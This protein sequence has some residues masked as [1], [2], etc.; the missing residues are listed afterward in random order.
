MGMMQGTLG[1][2]RSIRYSVSDSSGTECP[3]TWIDTTPNT[4]PSVPLNVKTPHTVEETPYDVLDEHTLHAQRS[5]FHAHQ[6]LNLSNLI[7]II[8]ISTL[9]YDDRSRK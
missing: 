7:G 6:Q 5:A 8:H 3:L 4:P 9:L 2:L 1:M